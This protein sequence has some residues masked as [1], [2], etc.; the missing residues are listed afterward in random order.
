LNEAA[1]TID[2]QAGEQVDRQAGSWQWAAVRVINVC[3]GARRRVRHRS[4]QKK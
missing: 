2:R 1:F 4:L 3:S